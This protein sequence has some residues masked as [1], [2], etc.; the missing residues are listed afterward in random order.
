MANATPSRLGQADASGA[1]DALWLKVFGGEVMAAFE[2]D[3]KF[4]D[5]QM[6][7]TI[8]NGKSAQFPATGRIAAAAYHTPGAEIVGSTVKHNERVIVID[9]LLV[10]SA[11]IANI[12]EAKNHYE[13][14]SVYSGEMGRTLAEAMDRNIAQVGVLAARA[15][16]TVNGHFGGSALTNAA[17]ATDG[18]VLAA[19]AFAAAQKLDEKFV[20]EN[21][22]FLALRAAQYYLLVQTTKVL[23]RDWDGAGSYSEAKVPKIASLSVVKS[24]HVPNTNVASGPTAYQGDFTK[25]VGLVWRRDAMGTVKLLDLAMESAYDIRRQGTLM[26]GKYAVGHGILRPEC[27][28]ELATP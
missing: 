28:V 7:R 24:Q 18:D 21:D 1:Q 15:T 10:S 14:R 16:A 8:S 25:T 5:K 22:R 12:D 11:F 9:D 17:M 2:E 13:V 27:A 23:N 3:N 26:V 20:P 4:L 19:Q 6:V